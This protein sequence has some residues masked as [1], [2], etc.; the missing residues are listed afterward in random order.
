MSNISILIKKLKSLDE[1]S[2]NFNLSPGVNVLCGENGVGKTTLM[3]VMS[4]LFDATALRRLF[5]S[6][7]DESTEIEFHFD[8]LSN[9]WRKNKN[10]T[11][12]N[13]IKK[14]GDIA[15]HG[16][17]ESSFIHGTRFKYTNV[18]MMNRDALFLK[19]D[20]K[21]LPSELVRSIGDIL[22]KN[23][24]YFS[25]IQYYYPIF[26]KKIRGSD[27]EEDVLAERPLFIFE[28]EGKK[29]STYEMSSGEFIVTS[30]VEYI[31]F[32]LEKI[33]SNKSKSNNKSQEVSIGIIDEIEVGLHP[34]ALNRLINYLSE[35]CDTHQVCL[36]LSTHSTNTLL[37]VKKENI[38][39]LSKRKSSSK[40]IVNVINPC[41][42]AY[43]IRS[44]KDSCGYDKIIFV[45][46]VLA[47]KIVE[48][49]INKINCGVNNLFKVIPIGGWR[50]VVE[51]YKEFRDEGLGGVFCDYVVI[52]DGDVEEDFLSEFG[53][54]SSKYRVEF[55]PIPSL[56]KFLFRKIIQN[57]DFDVFNKVEASLFNSSTDFLLDDVISK[58][59][60][61]NPQHLSK[62]KNGKKL[63]HAIITHS[64]SSGMDRTTAERLLCDIAMNDIYA[65]TGDSL[66]N[67]EVLQKS[68]IRFYQ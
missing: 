18:S 52:L 21:D 40:K 33:K 5:K 57:D 10:N 22:K 4:K 17:L 16:F 31:N 50:K 62:D 9:K 7:V 6:E 65:S 46:D 38:F 25:K 48:Q 41:Y 45:E 26:K 64:T 39:L 56:E 12:T 8:S 24:S 28:V 42:P 36:F 20:L 53:S 13:E 59:K 54:E 19:K 32:E 29:L 58:Y 66:T 23:P 35:L 2:F 68:L 67:E 47:K 43:A 51:I 15:F 1:I 30:L 44:T 61:D 11:W 14:D 27:E 3:N 60:K 49:Q 63:M 55:L 34:A 37:K